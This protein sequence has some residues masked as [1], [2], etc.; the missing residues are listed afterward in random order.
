MDYDLKSV[1]DILLAG[2]DRGYVN[3]DE[4]RDRMHLSPAGLKEY[5]VLENYIPV[6]MIGDQKK[7]IQEGE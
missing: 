3:G 1:S 2:S 4:W 5:K 6:D 7:L